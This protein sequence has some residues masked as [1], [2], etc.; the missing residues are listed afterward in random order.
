MF[1]GVNAIF[2]AVLG[3]FQKP[4]LMGELSLEGSRPQSL[5]SLCNLLLVCGGLDENVP[6]R[7]RD[8]HTW[9]PVTGA[10]GKAVEPL[11]VYS[12]TLLPAF[13]SLVSASF[14]G[15]RLPLLL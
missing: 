13:F 5:R 8:L 4:I 6:Q 1:L 12:F 15:H 9:S 3:V 2:S 7:R 11:G 14:S 10:V